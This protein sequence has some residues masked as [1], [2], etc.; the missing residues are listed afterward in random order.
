MQDVGPAI[1][2]INREGEAGSDLQC[3]FVEPKLP[4]LIFEQIRD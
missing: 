2:C 3:T 4:E 1:S